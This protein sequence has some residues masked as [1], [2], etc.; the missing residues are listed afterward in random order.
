MTDSIASSGVADDTANTGSIFPRVRLAAKGMPVGLSVGLIVIAG[1]AFSIWVTHGVTRG[2]D[3]GAG[4]KNASEGAMLASPPPLDVPPA[5]PVAIPV[6]PRP[7]PPQVQVKYIQSP[8]MIQYVDRPIA[9][10]P[11]APP[12]PPVDYSRLGEPALVIDRSTAG[13]PVAASDE[14]VRATVLRNRSTLI[15]QGAMIPAVLETPIDTTAPGQVRAVTTGDTRS[16][17]GTRIL[18][19]RG[20]RL[21]GD[22]R[23]EVVPGQHRVLI[24]WSRLIRPDGVAV[25]IGSP[26]TD[27]R[28]QAGVS[29]SVNNHFF[30]RVGMAL[31]QSA[32]SIGTN[33]ASRPNNGNSIIIGA[34]GQATDAISQSLQQ[35]VPPRPTIKVSAGT[36]VMVMVAHDLDFSGTLR[37]R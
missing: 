20:S 24:T 25:K 4:R 17:D 11:P 29:G 13:I 9:M 23:A 1:A 2:A 5:P 6:Q 37:Q 14:S 16:F 30:E 31:L 22:F 28:G 7:A 19:P 12:P 15:P 27:A 10:A 26:A 21:M 35:A 3:S 32:L 18:I 36:Q 34:T 8:P 33:I